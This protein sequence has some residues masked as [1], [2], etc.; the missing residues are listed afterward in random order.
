[1]KDYISEPYRIFFPLGTLFLLWGILLWVPLIWQAGDYPVLTHRFLML[2]GFTASFIA[3]FLMTAVP[4]FSGTFPARS[5]EV[6]GFLSLT[7]MGV[8]LVSWELEKGALLVSFLQPL[9][10]LLFLFSRIFKR[11]Q[12]PPYSFLFIFVGLMLWAFSALYGLIWDPEALRSLH[13]EGAIA[14]IILGVGGR[15]IPGILGHVEVVSA[16]RGLYERPVAL[17]KTVPLH[18]ALLILIFLSSYFLPGE[19]GIWPRALVVG[20]IAIFYWKLMKFPRE[21]SALTWSI[22]ISAWLI[23]GSFL[24]RALWSDASIH[25][26]HSFFIN[27]IALLCFLVATRVLQSHGPQRKEL[28]NSRLLYVVTG[29]IVAAALTR[30][31]AYLMPD[32]YL[33]HLAYSAL[34]LAVAALAWG[35]KYLR[36]ARTFPAR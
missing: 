10:I 12:N 6:G 9:F 22:W 15:L 5:W 16:Q 1:M 17:W 13:Y 27:G 19:M 29:I 14:S 32:A 28:E 4:K 3:G 21:R 23:V 25:I 26:S 20:L 31:C 35:L 7:L 11:K 8:L 30:V 33:N 36:F 24:A 34:C 2:N 18:F